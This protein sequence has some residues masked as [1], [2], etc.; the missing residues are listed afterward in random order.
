MPREL[1]LPQ[2]PA[3]AGPGIR[4]APGDTKRQTFRPDAPGTWPG[5]LPTLSWHGLDLLLPPKPEGAT[6]PLAANPARTPPLD[7]SANARFE[8]R[9]HTANVG[10]K[11]RG[12]DANPAKPARS[13]PRVRLSDLL[14]GAKALPLEAP[15]KAEPWQRFLQEMRLP[16]ACRLHRPFF[17][18]ALQPQK[19]RSCYASAGGFRSLHQ[20]FE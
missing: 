7:D 4:L 16:H 17:S 3:E 12:H 9:I 14:F 2:L 20:T 10:T 13:L 15:P 8:L 5:G 1:N 6:E 18:R 11:R 19:H